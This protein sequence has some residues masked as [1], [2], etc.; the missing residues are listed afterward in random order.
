MNKVFVT[1]DLEEWYNLDYLKTYKIAEAEIE[2]IPQI[3]R[4]LDLLDRLEIKATFFVLA[5]LAHKNESII[6]EIHK[7]GHE[8]SCHGLDHD[9]LCN[10]TDDD[11]CSQIT[12]AKKILDSIIGENK[13]CGYRAS[14]FSMDRKKL[15]LLASCGY[16]YDSSY[17]CFTQHPL[18][19][20]LDLS[21]FEKSDDLIYRKNGMYVFEIP[22]LEIIKMFIPIS[23]GGYLRLFPFCLIKLLIKKYAKKHSNF[24]I[25]L[26]P[27]ELTDIPLP[28]PKDISLGKRF[29]ASIGRKGNLIKIEKLLLLLRGMGAEFYKINQYCCEQ[30]ENQCSPK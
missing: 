23:G 5:E 17:I 30:E 15:D 25:Y 24:L 27:F 10:K 14:C 19:G 26:H 3:I 2:T 8:I 13:I 1:V 22:T 16:R 29:R 4:F 6:R 28:F 12:E 18:Y 11:F 9:L 21:G 20:D 7:R